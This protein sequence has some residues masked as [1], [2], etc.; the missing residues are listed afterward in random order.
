LLETGRGTLKL[1]EFRAGY[2]PPVSL[3]P[4]EQV[5][6]VISGKVEFRIGDDKTQICGPGD[7]VVI[8]GNVPHEGHFVEETKMLSIFLP[9]AT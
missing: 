9:A 6:Y 5:S 3:H 7:I 1:W 4:E 2:K 8:P